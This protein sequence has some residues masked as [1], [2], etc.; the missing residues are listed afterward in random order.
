MQQHLRQI[1]IPSLIIAIFIIADT[2]IKQINLFHFTKWGLWGF[3]IAIALVT[4]LVTSYGLKKD[5]KAFHVYYF[6]SMGIRLFLSVIFVF[7]CIIL[8]M[9]G[10]YSFVITFFV[11]YFLY[12]VFEIYFLLGNLRAKSE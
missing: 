1:G 12:F 3:F 7:V 2:F 9:E 11:F 10:I 5:E 8:R 4:S 6:L